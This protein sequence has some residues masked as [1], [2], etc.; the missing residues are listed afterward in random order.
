MLQLVRDQLDNVAD[1]WNKAMADGGC[2]CGK[3]QMP[4]AVAKTT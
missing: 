3:V 2:L 4:D 1:R